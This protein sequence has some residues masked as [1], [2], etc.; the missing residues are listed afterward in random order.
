MHRQT[1]TKLV[2]LL[3]QKLKVR[4][5]YVPEIFKSKIRDTIINFSIH[6]QTEQGSK[7]IKFTKDTRANQL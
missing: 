3:Y 5:H 4:Y 7:R 1:C 2:G 6:H